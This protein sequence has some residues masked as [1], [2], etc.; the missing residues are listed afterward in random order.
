MLF[1]FAPL[2][3]QYHRPCVAISADGLTRPILL[4][5]DGAGPDAAWR[6]MQRRPA[7]HL[8]AWQRG[9]LDA[10]DMREIAA[11]ALRERGL[12]PRTATWDQIQAQAG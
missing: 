9:P 11:R 6:V 10:L 1:R 3:H 12:D 8:P 7:G 4:V 2:D 5:R